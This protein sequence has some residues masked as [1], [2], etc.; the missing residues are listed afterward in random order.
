MNKRRALQDDIFIV[1]RLP[2][3]RPVVQYIRQSTRKQLRQNRFSADMQDQDMRDKLLWHGWT[4]ELILQAI[5][6]DTGKSGTKRRDEREGLDDL[7]RLIETDS[8]GAAAAYNVSRIYRALS[9]AEVG[10]FCDLV[11]EH[12]VPIITKRRIY[13][14][15][16]DDN[17]DL[18]ADFQAAADYIEDH[19]LGVV[20]AARDYNVAENAAY[21]GNSLPIGFQV[22][23]DGERKRYA[24]YTPHAEKIRWLF[25]R[26]HEL[27]GN[28]PLL[29]RE[30]VH[31]NFRFP[32]LGPGIVAPIRLRQDEDG[33][34]LLRNRATLI[35]VLTN[36]A[37]IGIYT[38]GDSEHKD[39]HDA[40]VPIDDFMFAYERLSP[41]DLAGNER[42]KKASEKRY[43]GAKA[44]LDGVLRS[45]DL[46]V[47]TFDDHYV[48]VDDNDRWI[49]KEIMVC[50]ANI[51]AAFTCCFEHVLEKL[52]NSN[53]AE[54]LH[55]KIE[56]ARVKQQAQAA[57]YTKSLVRIDQEIANAEMAQRVSKN[58]GDE[59]GY[60]EATKQLVQLRKD[61]TAIEAK[62]QE[63]SHEATE[64]AQCHDLVD[65]ALCDWCNMKME[66]KKRLVKLMMPVADITAPSIHF[67]RLRCFF[68]TPY[69]RTMDMLIYRKDGNR[70]VWTPE[71]E[72]VLRQVFS[73]RTREQIMAAL[74][75]CS[76]GSINQRARQMGLR[77]INPYTPEKYPLTYS[78]LQFMAETGAKVDQVVW[79]MARENEGTGQALSAS[80]Q[81]IA[82]CLTTQPIRQPGASTTTSPV[83][84]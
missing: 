67:I 39:A 55:A 78:D 61:K 81:A 12:R 37:Y 20:V 44:L 31:T 27:N 30:L 62:Q 79:Y 17:K 53:R 64:L 14:P 56:E 60:T 40:I 59:F 71:E 82:M 48:A 47:Y 6:K 3:D 49:R 2:I 41:V 72:T 45:D 10:A 8:V 5:S 83:E 57:D 76:W 19:I 21:G 84:Q 28:L 63:A 69:N 51:D 18:Q 11:L 52:N 32:P 23:D 73:S 25:R 24:E 43:G 36:K 50:V 80:L 34:Y 1:P 68:G 75:T 77:A 26:Y 22:I 66:E 54:Q 33:Y 42:E 70:H 16:R 46:P 29:Y 74:P 9:K 7:Y 65:K 4:S 35:Y 13:W 15:N 38:Y 58:L